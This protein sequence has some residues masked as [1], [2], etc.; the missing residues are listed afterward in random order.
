MKYRYLTDQELQILEKDFVQFLV[1][2]G[3]DN[4][5]WVRVNE[6]SKEKALE[7]VG[8]FSD[9]VIEKAIEN[10]KYLEYRSAKSLKIFHCKDE[11]ISLI[12][13]DIDENSTLDFTEANSAEKAINEGTDAIKTYKTKKA[14][15]PSRTEELF[16]MMDAGCYIVD[17]KFYNTLNHLR[18]VYQN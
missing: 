12:G 13:L 15:H 9:V 11:E 18:K 6:E 14:Y 8:L 2:N 1:A 10:I 5:E 3:I 17:G 7:I 16:K 4:D